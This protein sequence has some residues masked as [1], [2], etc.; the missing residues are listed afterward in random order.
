MI[1]FCGPAAGGATYGGWNASGW[2]TSGGEVMK[3]ALGVVA[4][5]VLLVLV[6]GGSLM[7]SRNELVTERT[8][9]KRH[10]RRWMWRCSAA[11]I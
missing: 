2:N 7:G 11:R 1:E 3:I 6:F 8:P 10:G 4:V 5:I 9:W